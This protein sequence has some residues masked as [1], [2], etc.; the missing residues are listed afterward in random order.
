M[1]TLRFIKGFT[2]QFFSIFLNLCMLCISIF[3]AFKVSP[4][5]FATAI[6]LGMQDAFWMTAKKEGDSSKGQFEFWFYHLSRMWVY[7]LAF[8][9]FVVE[10]ILISF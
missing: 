10:Y 7:T 2:T 9:S 8:L 5:L 6:W 3:C 1:T 4:I